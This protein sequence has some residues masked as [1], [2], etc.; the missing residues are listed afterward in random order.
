MNLAATFP[1]VL[2][3]YL[4][5]R[6]IK[7]PLL[8]LF[9]LSL[10]TILLHA[11]AHLSINNTGFLNVAVV[12]FVH[13]TPI[14][15]LAGPS[16]YLFIRLSIKG[17]NIRWTDSIHLIPFIIQLIAIT[18]YILTPLSEKVN[19]VQSIISNPAL[20]RSLDVNLF[21]STGFAYFLRSALFV[22]YLI[23]G[24][25]VIAKAEKSKNSKDISRI[26]SLKR[27]SWLMI[28]LTV[29]YSVHIILVANGDDYRNWM[30]N[31]VIFIDFILFTILFA[32]LSRHPELIYNSRMLRRGYLKESP[33]VLAPKKENQLPEEI[34]RAIDSKIASLVKEKKFFAN[35]HSNFDSFARAIGQS[36]YH[37][38][39]YLKMKDASFMDLKNKNRIQIAKELLESRRHYKIEYVAHKSG[40]DSLSN[41]FK[42]FKR[43]L[44]CTPDE[45]RKMIHAARA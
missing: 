31:S 14:Y 20:Q 2:F 34:F 39:S 36:K 4:F 22:F 30:I 43:T 25:V 23:F 37:I 7:K 38:R 28:F 45:Y 9:Y 8:A 41:F 13:A 44:K 40:F 42:I 1:L 11:V 24:L 6:H 5:I 12:L 17:Q 16:F 32:E 19:I 21:F 3:I 35:P 15:L 10:F 18:P 26:N 33:F 27:I 29:A